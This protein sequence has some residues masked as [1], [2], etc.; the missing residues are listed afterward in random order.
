MARNTRRR[1]RRQ[2]GIQQR[3]SE[4]SPNAESPAP[5]SVVHTFCGFLLYDLSLRYP[6]V[7]CTAERCFVV[8]VLP[9]VAVGVLVHRTHVVLAGGARRTARFHSTNET[10]VGETRF[11]SFSSSSMNPVLY[12]YVI[13]LIYA[14]WR[15]LSHLLYCWKT[16]QAYCKNRINA[17]EKTLATRSRLQN[18]SSSARSRVV[19]EERYDVYLPPRNV[20]TST[21]TTVVVPC[22]FFLFP[23]ALV[24]YRCYTDVA[25]ALS[26]LGV[27]VVVQNTEPFRLSAWIYGSNDDFAKQTMRQVEERHS[28]RVQEWSVGGHS[29][30]R[31]ENRSDIFV[32]D[33]HFLTVLSTC[34]VRWLLCRVDLP[35]LVLSRSCQECL[36][37]SSFTVC[38]DLC[39]FRELESTC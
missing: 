11:S 34:F 10:S 9:P 20:D 36:R 3:A 5:S 16:A 19:F 23:G 1:K 27:L 22:G 12:F 32:S 28:F 6:R 29:M 26:N 25:L 17:S 38:I 31:C 24:D 30:V 4:A 35:A 39:P 7:C 18:S 13:L 2:P 33:K 8:A 37:S 21:S 14:L 15:I